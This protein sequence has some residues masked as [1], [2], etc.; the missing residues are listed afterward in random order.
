MKHFYTKPN[1]RPFS[2]RSA[3]VVI[4]L[5][6]SHSLVRSDCDRRAH[7]AEGSSLHAHPEIARCI[8]LDVDEFAWVS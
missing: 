3:L 2:Q 6:L 4:G 1:L 7:S 8:H 5:K